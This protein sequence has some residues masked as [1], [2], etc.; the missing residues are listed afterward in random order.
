VRFLQAPSF[1]CSLRRFGFVSAAAAIAL[2]LIEGVIV[3]T[4]IWHPLGCII[5]VGGGGGWSRGLHRRR[6]H[7][8]GIDGI[9]LTHLL[10]FI[11]VVEDDDVSVTGRPK[12][13]AVEVVEELPSELL[14]M[15]GV[16]EENL[17]VRR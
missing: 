2:C 17:L 3:I 1:C 9:L 14:I 7:N 8:I 4:I 5:S 12:K 6:W 11:E 10:F 13:T 16:R 15:Q